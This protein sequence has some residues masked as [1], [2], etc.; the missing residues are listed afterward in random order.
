MVHLNAGFAGR[1]DRE[2][3]KALLEMLDHFEGTEGSANENHEESKNPGVESSADHAL[4]SA[5][6]DRQNLGAAPHEAHQREGRGLKGTVG[7]NLMAEGVAAAAPRGG[8]GGEVRE[9]NPYARHR[10]LSTLNA[11]E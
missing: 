11:E 5:A 2:K 1:L 10:T 9:V 7:D 8:G 3:Q 4:S 6:K